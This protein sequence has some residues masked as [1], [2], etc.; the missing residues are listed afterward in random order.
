[1]VSARAPI[2]TEAK[3]NPLAK[4][5]DFFSVLNGLFLVELGGFEPPTS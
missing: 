2:S 1:M 4:L 3:R 5:E